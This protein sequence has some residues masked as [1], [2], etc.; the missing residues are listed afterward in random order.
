MITALKSQEV[1]DMASS[2]QPMQIACAMNSCVALSTY[3]NGRMLGQRWHP[4]HYQLFV[5]VYVGER[6]GS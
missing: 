4:D 6:A 3:S 5:P 2:G 1:P